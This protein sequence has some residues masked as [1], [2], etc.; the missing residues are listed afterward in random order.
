MAHTPVRVLTLFFLNAVSGL[1]IKNDQTSDAETCWITSYSSGG[2]GHQL[3]GMITTMGLHGLPLPQNPETIIQY[4]ALDRKFEIDTEGQRVKDSEL[5]DVE[6][7]LRTANANFHDQ[8]CQKYPCDPMNHQR[9]EKIGNSIRNIAEGHCESGVTYQTSTAISGFEEGA[10]ENEDVKKNIGELA[11]LFTDLLPNHSL[12]NGRSVVMH[13]RLGDSKGRGSHPGHRAFDPLQMEKLRPMES[14]SEEAQFDLQMS[15]AKDVLDGIEQKLG[16]DN[17]I[18]HT[19]DEHRVAKRFLKNGGKN[20][21]IFGVDTPVL[22]ALSQ[23][24]NADILVAS[25]SAL[26]IAAA[27]LRDPKGQKEDTTFI[28]RER[29]AMMP[30]HKT[31]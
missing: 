19:D 14:E 10:R 17:I 20:T 23:M 9:W 31:Y 12:P 8:R 30:P 29:G 27:F 25:N 4:D 11:P 21:K 18:I 2:F 13:I 7:F 28:P 24:V 26:S 3:L 15:K 6:E 1:R 16:Y 5:Q 22:L